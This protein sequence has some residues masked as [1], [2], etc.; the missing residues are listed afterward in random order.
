M[1]ERKKEHSLNR[2]ERGLSKRN[3]SSQ[4]FK[5][6]GIYGIMQLSKNQSSEEYFGCPV[7]EK[8]VRIYT[9]L[10]FRNRKNKEHIADFLKLSA[11]FYA[12]TKNFDE[13][14]QRKS[15]EK[16]RYENKSF[17]EA[18]IKKKKEY[19]LTESVT[20]NEYLATEA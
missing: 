19:T 4:K 18:V 7:E 3:D 6:K 17:T 13:K 10:V 8:K 11:Q 5:S 1:V 12:K 14:L 2:D 15:C 20:F 9:D 16:V